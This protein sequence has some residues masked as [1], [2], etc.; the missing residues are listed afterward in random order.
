LKNVLSPA[1]RKQ[2]EKRV[3]EVFADEVK[4]LP[5]ELQQI[6]ADDLVTAFQNRM[7]VLLRI[8]SK[9]AH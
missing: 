5:Q 4:A 8:Q 6:L 1:G 7:T 2:L 3:M 9:R